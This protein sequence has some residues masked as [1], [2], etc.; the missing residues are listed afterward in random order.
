MLSKVK[1]FS[2]KLKSSNPSS[3]TL[4]TRYYIKM[5]GPHSKGSAE[6]AIYQMDESMRDPSV[7]GMEEMTTFSKDGGLPSTKGTGDDIQSMRGRNMVAAR[8]G[9]GSYGEN[10]ERLTTNGKYSGDRV[11]KTLI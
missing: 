6:V 2:Q 9:E 7:R 3:H 10:G 4:P 5:N 8:E 11:Y 1:R